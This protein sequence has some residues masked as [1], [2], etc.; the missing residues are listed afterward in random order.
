MLNKLSFKTLNSVNAR[1]NKI[2]EE[3]HLKL[4]TQ[5]GLSD[6]RVPG[7]GLVIKTERGSG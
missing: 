2:L 3:P 6:P 5:S 7:E 1:F 4:Q